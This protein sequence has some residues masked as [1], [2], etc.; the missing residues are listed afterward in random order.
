MLQG[1]PFLTAES[2]SSVRYKNEYQHCKVLATI[3][4]LSHPKICPS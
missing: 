4:P 2:P 3:N 1:I